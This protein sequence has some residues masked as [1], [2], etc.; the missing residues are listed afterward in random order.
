MREPKIENKYNLK[1]SDVGRMV[2]VD[3]SKL[4]EPLFWRNDVINAWCIS[5]S[6]GTDWERRYCNDNSVWIGI[7]DKP[8]YKKDVHYRCDCW[9]GMGNYKFKSF[10]DMRE[11]ER[12][13]DLETQETLLEYLNM[14]LDEGIV[15]LK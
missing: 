13:K 1:P 15:E 7:Y 2:V 4:K 5:K 3:R 11:I 9:G 8:Y 6:I 12:E 10:F 14:L